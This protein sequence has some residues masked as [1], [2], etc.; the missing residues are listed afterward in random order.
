MLCSIPPRYLLPL[1]LLCWAA[2]GSAVLPHFDLQVGACLAT[3]LPGDRSCYL[4]VFP[5]M[6]LLCAIPAGGDRCA[7][8][9]AF[10]AVF[11]FCIRRCLCCWVLLP[12]R[13]GRC[14]TTR[15][16]PSCAFPSSLLLLP[17]FQS[18][19]VTGVFW[20]LLCPY[21]L[22]ACVECICAFS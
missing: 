2:G 11:A 13:Y 5:S 3:V 1:L 6:H 19:L 4:N 21:S 18:H 7:T 16:S 15:D 9:L 22:P 8:Y 17:I 20:S 14:C 10:C 12:G